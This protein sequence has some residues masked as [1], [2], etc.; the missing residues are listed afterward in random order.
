MSD[1]RRR[2]G[3]KMSFADRDK[4]R[5]ERRSRDDRQSGPG[6]DRSQKAYRAALERAFDS[7]K[8][9]ELAATLTSRRPARPPAAPKKPRPAAEPKPA[10]T[11]PRA[12][13][14]SRRSVLLDNIRKADGGAKISAAID[15]YLG[16]FETLPNDYELLEKALDHRSAAV[17]LTVLAHIEAQVARAKP[18][19]S[20]SLAMKLAI[21]VDTHDDDDVCTLAA[22]VRAAL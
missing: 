15:R 16:E 6:R 1:D 4:R 21:L 22:R 8:V 11:K 14:P 20:R 7:G 10:A 2:D 19:R 3:S 12:P 18:R 5:R 9:D 17:V 13:K